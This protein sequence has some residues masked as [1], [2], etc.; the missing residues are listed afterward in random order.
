M[1]LTSWILHYV[2]LFVTTYLCNQ[3]LTHR[4]L[5]SQTDTPH[6]QNI[7][8]QATCYATF[9][10]H[11]YPHCIQCQIHNVT[12]NAKS[13]LLC[14]RQQIYRNTFVA[15]NW[16]KPRANLISLNQLLSYAWWQVNPEEG[17]HFEMATNYLH[18]SLCLLFQ[19]L[20]Y[21]TSI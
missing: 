21:T 7:S 6:L 3:L 4:T 11:K 13:Q 20:T 18:S 5:K 10:A 12:N 9:R 19:F 14:N 2:H 17:K 8:K 16:K 1:L 15:V